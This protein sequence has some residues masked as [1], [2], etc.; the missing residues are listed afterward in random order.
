MNVLVHR[1]NDGQFCVRYGDNIAVAT[2]V[3]YAV[4]KLL[5]SLRFGG[6]SNPH[7]GEITQ[8]DLESIPYKL[9]HTINPP[10]PVVDDK[11]LTILWLKNHLTHIWD[12]II[13]PP[14]YKDYDPET[15]A[16]LKKHSEVFL[17]AHLAKCTD[18]DKQPWEQGPTF[19]EFKKMVLKELSEPHVGDCTAVAMT[20]YRCYLENLLGQDSCTFYKYEGNR[21]LHD[22]EDKAFWASILSHDA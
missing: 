17:K 18:D 3:K 7:L 10:C 20:C 11:D 22:Y 2:T 9:Y 16:S 15:T 4:Q 19:D 8:R 21:L 13:L 1:T 5:A 6:V 14:T 12:D